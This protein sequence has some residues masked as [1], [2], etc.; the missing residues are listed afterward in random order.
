MGKGRERDRVEGRWRREEIGVGV[1]RGAV[2][3]QEVGGE[4]GGAWRGAQ[5]AV[6]GEVVGSRKARGLEGSEEDMGGL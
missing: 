5:R 6:G 3:S 4:L 2:G 1:G